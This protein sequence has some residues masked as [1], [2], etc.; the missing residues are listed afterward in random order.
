MSA[1]RR[2]RSSAEASWWGSS[3]FKNLEALLVVAGMY[4]VLTI[5][6][7]YFQSRLETPGLEGL[8]AWADQPGSRTG[9]KKMTFQM[10]GGEPGRA[11]EAA[12]S[13]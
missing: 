13:S 9:R 8:R 11:G 2:R 7:T 3:D 5:I 1:W 10:G 12:A 4:W 6:F